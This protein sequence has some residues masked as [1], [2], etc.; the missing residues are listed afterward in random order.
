M[1]TAAKSIGIRPATVS[2][3]C[4]GKID[5]GKAEVRTL[6][7]LATL[8]NCSVDE[9]IIRGEK[10]Q[11]IETGI[12][13]LDFFAPLVKEGTTGLVARPGMGQ[14]VILAELLHNFKASK[15]KTLFLL[16]EVEHKELDGTVDLADVTTTSI[17]ET[18][19]KFRDSTSEV[20]F[21]TDRSYVV[22][23]ELLDLQ[24]K[25]LEENMSPVTTIL[26]DL[27]GE[28]VDEDI[29]YG[30]L[31]TVWQLDA[32]LVARHYY[33]AVHPL[34][35]TSS[36]LEGVDLDQRHFTLRQRAI[37]LLRRYRELRAFVAVHGTGRIPASET[38]T[39]ERG[40]RLEAYFT[41]PF[42]VAEEFTKQ[43]GTSV[44][45]SDTLN[46]VETILDGKMDEVQVESLKFVGALS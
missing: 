33:P 41:Q 34:Y 7:G 36:L 26:V 18:L 19:G 4:T 35:S 23:G 20:I 17:E 9:L 29:P 1:T 27:S 24:E 45:L 38:E 32:E 22:S 11:M 43:P 15:Y 46:D 6:V 28:V 5:L 8:A 13:A 2:N 10:V 25:L 39:Y 12:K 37:K 14:L 30:P 21:I 31:E 16:P 44:A 40:S 3:L 42:A